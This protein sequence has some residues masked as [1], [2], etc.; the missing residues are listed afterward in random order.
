MG[1]YFCGS[2]DPAAIQDCTKFLSLMTNL[3]LQLVRDII[4]EV[5]YQ[6]YEKRLEQPKSLGPS[7]TVPTQLVLI[8]TVAIII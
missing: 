5:C 1:I 4:N 2:L 6:R 8:W 3:L 7:L